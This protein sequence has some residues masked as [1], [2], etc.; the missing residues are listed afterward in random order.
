M[1][2]QLRKI[3]F[4]R[5]TQSSALYFQSNADLS[6]II[7]DEMNARLL[8]SFLYFDDSRELSFLNAFVSFNALEGRQAQPGAA[9]KLGL[10][11]A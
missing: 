11:P 9:C 10:A 8:E 2:R 5:S 7:F 3:T 6:S 1:R 4:I